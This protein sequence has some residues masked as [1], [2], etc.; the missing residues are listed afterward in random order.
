MARYATM[1]ALQAI[2]V[3]FVMTFLLFAL[4]NVMPGDPVENMLEGNPSLTPELIESM[5]QLYGVGVPLH[6]RYWNWLMAAFQ[7]DFGYSSLYF[8]PVLVI[9]WPA[10]VETLKLMAATVIISVPLALVFGAIAAI[11][12][13]GWVD[14][15]ISLFAFA[16]IAIPNFWQALILIIIFAAQLGWL[17]ASGVPLRPGASVGTQMVHL[18]LPLVVLVTSFVGPLLRYV[19]AS[20]IETLGSDYVRTARSKGLSET[21]VLF[22]HAL[23]NALLPMVTVLALGFGNLL[24]GSLVVETI[25]GIMGMGKVIFDAVRYVDFNLA[26]VALLMATLVTLVCNFLADIAYA[27]LDPR[28]SL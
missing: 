7:G 25:F 17:P 22:R 18:I 2:V 5:R 21:S 15:A 3:M 6:V 20:M 16:S 28:I 13:G 10:I 19:R 8:R 9:L 14:N 26:L 27:W 23:R 12:P 1:R 4:I 24:S 11:R